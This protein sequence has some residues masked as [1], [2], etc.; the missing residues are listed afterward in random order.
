MA[1]FKG[2][3]AAHLLLGALLYLTP[4]F[5]NHYPFIFFDTAHYI[6]LG[7]TILHA[8]HIELPL[9]QHAGGEDAADAVADHGGAHM[10]LTYVGGRS[11]YYGVFATLLVGVAGFWAVAAAQALVAAWL[12]W[13]TTGAVAVRRQTLR[14]YAMVLLL[15]AGSSLPF[16]VALAMP[17]VFAGFGIVALLLL[18]CGPRYALPQRV[19]LV[20]IAAFSAASH[21]T[22][23]PLMALVAGISMVF[24][25]RQGEP[26]RL[27]LRRHALPLT[28]LVIALAG[29]AAFDLACRAA[30]G[31]APHA[32]PYLMA[33]VLADGPGRAYLDV[34]CQEPDRFA[35]CAFRN[36]ALDDSDEILWSDKPGEGVYT[37]LDYDGR[38]RMLREQRDFV[39]GALAHAPGMA[40]A[41]AADNF[42]QQLTYMGVRDDVGA[43]KTSWDTL[44]GDAAPGTE[45]GVTGSLS[46]RGA[47]PF[48]VIDGIDAAVLALSV[49]FLAVRLTRHD[50][51]GGWRSARPAANGLVTMAVGVVVLILANA[52]MCGILSE[53]DERY[54][55]RLIWLLPALALVT[56]QRVGLPVRLRARR[57]SAV[58]GR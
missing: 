35:I 6:D 24:F 2:I 45:P 34:A 36:Q 58:I 31:E 30:F 40:L 28:A 51:R 4:S 3:A 56:A 25:A 44:V 27:N 48:G 1:R 14:Y 20:G 12:T 43:T 19:A 38:L 57:P 15:A 21:A 13:I 17:D 18:S 54:E 23:L 49:A 55:S 39:L 53:P 46:Y 32:P 16:F 26:L 33:R 5:I 41:A 42:A 47:M 11:P 50:V 7:K 29:G 22:I 10:S 52:A 9:L 37:T 8:A